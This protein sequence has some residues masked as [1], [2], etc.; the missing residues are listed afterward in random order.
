MQSPCTGLSVVLALTTGLSAVIVGL[1]SDPAD[2]RRGFRATFRSTGA[3]TSTTR[4]VARPIRSAEESARLK[5][6]ESRINW[7]EASRFGLDVAKSL[8]EKAIGN[9]LSAPSP[10]TT[11]AFSSSTLNPVEL[12][13]CIRESKWL[14]DAS[15]GL[16][17]RSD[18]LKQESSRIEQAGMLVEG[19]RSR[20]NRSSQRSVDA[21]NARIEEH[22]RMVTHYNTV[23]LPQ[24]RREQDDFNRR[25]EQFNRYCNG[26]SYYADDLAEIESK[27]GLKT[28]N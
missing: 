3:V 13:A 17:T 1:V 2:A 4:T 25:V 7:S 15:L 11:T 22:R 19:D 27:L 28:V 6:V 21:F 20:V 18:Q 10:S 24:V 5:Q 8:I 12:E 26:R 14:D 16:D 23:L 9:S